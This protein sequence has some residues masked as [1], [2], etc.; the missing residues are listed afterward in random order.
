MSPLNIT[1]LLHIYAIVPD[2]RDCQLNKSHSRSEAVTETFQSFEAEGL[3]MKIIPDEEWHA[4][5]EHT[6]ASQYRIT[7]KGEAMVDAICAV[8]VPVCKWV[9]P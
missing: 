1:M 9:Q 6:R 2:Y 4:A 5:S 3:I 8:K 7:E